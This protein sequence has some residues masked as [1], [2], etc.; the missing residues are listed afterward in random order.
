MNRPHSVSCHAFASMIV[1]DFNVPRAVVSPAKADSPLVVDPDAVLPTSIAGKFLE[2]V[3][4]RDAKVVQIL[5][6]I[7]NL[8]LALGLR[9]EGAEPT[10]RT[11]PEKFLGVAR[12]KRPNHLPDI[13]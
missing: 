7:E 9:L 2:P 5:G 1:D 6:A 4:G 8:Q 3:A 11:A 10:R 13:V 12:C